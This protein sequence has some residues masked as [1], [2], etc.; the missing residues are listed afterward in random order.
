MKC[1]WKLIVEGRLI[2][3]QGKK[4]YFQELGK[5]FGK[6]LR[7]ECYKK[8]PC[9]CQKLKLGQ[10][11]LTDGPVKYLGTSTRKREQ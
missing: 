11:A 5:A 7:E 4:K 3:S 1:K 6:T 10:P 2:S 9:I 8:S